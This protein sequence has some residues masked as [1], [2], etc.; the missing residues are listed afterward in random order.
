M[1]R[2]ILVPLDGSTFAEAALAPACAIA[3]R[4]RATLHLAHVHQFVTANPIYIKD[5]AVID[6]HLNSRAR[7]HESIYLEHT[8]ATL[9]ATHPA[10]TCESRLLEPGVR[11]TSDWTIAGA[12]V[13]YISA[14]DIDLV[15]MTSHGRGGLARFWLGS[16]ATA[17]L[18]LC[19]APILLVR[20]S[21]P[22]GEDKPY[23]RILV[24]HDGSEAAERM[25]YRALAFGRL[26]G[27]EYCLLRIVEPT[28]PFGAAPLVQPTDLDPDRTDRLCAEARADLERVA[29]WMI[30]AG[31]TV[32]TEVRVSLHP[33]LAILEAADGL[34]IDVIAMATRGRSGLQR[35]ILGSVTDKVVRGARQ[36]MLVYAPRLAPE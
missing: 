32:T 7:E 6:E 36:T 34:E 35:A 17:L 1:Y 27:A 29:A 13:D 31:A 25:V 20:S 24:P 3:Q 28:A 16:V 4:A 11:F 26:L 23:R 5:V 33:A 30:S 8:R 19:S 22:A 18:P 21:M 14:V 10:L 15:V 9:I 2:S 12:L